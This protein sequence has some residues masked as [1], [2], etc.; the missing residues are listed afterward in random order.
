MVLAPADFYAYSRATGVPVPEDPE[1][2]AQIAPEVLAFR[3]NQLVAPREES[4]LLQNLG[5]AAAGLGLAGLGAFGARRLLRRQPA[6]AE[7][8]VSGRQPSEE[9]V[10]QVAKTSAIGNV[11]RDLNQPP[12]KVDVEPSKTVNTGTAPDRA[13]QLIDELGEELELKRQTRQVQ[14]V[15]AK[16]KAQAQNILAE[17]RREQQ[18]EP[19]TPVT[20]IFPHTILPTRAYQPG[21][22]SDLTSIQESLLNQ[23]RNQTVNA[24]ESGEDQ[25]AQLS[26]RSLKRSAGNKTSPVLQ[27]L[28]DSGL[29]DFEINARINAYAQYGK[30]EFL[31]P[32][33]NASTVGKENFARTLE[34]ANAQFDELGNLASG[35]YAAGTRN[36]SIAGGGTVQLP[37]GEMRRSAFAGTE[38]KTLRV[39][40][41]DDDESWEPISQGLTGLRGGVT[42]AA[43]PIK[44]SEQYETAIQNFRDHWDQQVNAYL[45]GQQSGG[46]TRP[47]RRD[48]NIDVHD[49]NMP[50]RIRNVEGVNEDG[51]LVS[52]Q[53][54][55]LYRD[56]LPQETVE[57][58]ER[59]EPIR[60]AVPFLVD[61]H[62]AIAVAEANP[63]MENRLD[64]EHYRATGRA[65]VRAHE[66]IVGPYENDQ[67][68]ADLEPGSYYQEVANLGGKPDVTPERGTG[69]QKGRLVGGTAEPPVREPVYNLF[70]APHTTTSGKQI[71]IN[72]ATIAD[73][74]GNLQDINISTLK[75]LNELG[76]A[77]DAQGSKLYVSP[78]QQL[79]FI[80]T[81][82]MAVKRPIGNAAP[83]GKVTRRGQY[84]SFT[85][86]VYEAAD[87]IVNA[88]LQV[89][90]ATTGQPVTAAGQINREEFAGFL[91][92]LRFST[93]TK[94]Y[95][96]L[97]ALA[98]KVLAE[99]KN[100]TLPV[101]ESPTAF[102]FIEGIIGRP[103]SRLSRKS[104]VTVNSKT[105]EVYPL[106][107][108]EAKSLGF[109]GGSV[110]DSMQGRKYVGPPSLDI[111]ES[112]KSLESWSR[113][114][115]GTEDWEQT[116][117][118]P[119]ESLG[120]ASMG[121]LLPRRQGPL[122]QRLAPATTGVG[123][124]LQSTREQL[125]KIKPEEVKF[126]SEQPISNLGAVTQQLMA[127][128]GRRAAKRRNR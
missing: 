58:V 69:S 52:R 66:K 49:L 63:T 102:D 27:Q 98:N 12:T 9:A 5:L 74:Q 76:P 7:E 16:E 39:R 94:D 126:S 48:R 100:I 10:R 77:V 26:Q 59:G 121:P 41:Q 84:G 103:G 37:Q 33:Y 34:I 114:G 31:D 25:V 6:A 90:D 127:Q 87:T 17:F 91:N 101:L 61:K 14:E 82:P 29:N 28:Y 107:A 118:F 83:V 120:L 117:D 111:R 42:V 32:H 97:G 78:G 73:P 51:D 72:K 3:R 55:I 62:R 108:E 112:P 20:E 109:A 113:M 43:L 35:E 45:S 53:E 89:H 40:N 60:E 79:N 92:N 18:R 115:E 124:Q 4:N 65:L 68:I 80:Q 24:V 86:D 104:F 119:E 106:S 71:L 56:I 23:A 88:P 125:A 15:E 116:K 99:E 105:G 47:A 50:V 93:G 122:Q 22:F 13:S 67:Y 30:Q 8:L 81:Q 2:R 96:E 95:S 128:A 36:V 38:P 64:A 19:P 123:A 11:V 75:H 21:S 85:N 110:A 70:Y 1:E 44:Q 54:T 46:I 57:A